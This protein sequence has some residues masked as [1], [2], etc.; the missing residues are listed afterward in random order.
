MVAQLVES[1]GLHCRNPVVVGSNSVWG[2][3]VVVFFTVFLGLCPQ[4]LCLLCAWACHV[5]VRASAGELCTMLGQV[6]GQ[7][8]IGK[9]GS[10]SPLASH[11]ERVSGKI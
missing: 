11:T 4:L 10:V 6:E 5:H 1:T 2:S 9:A 7:R 8:R 3:S